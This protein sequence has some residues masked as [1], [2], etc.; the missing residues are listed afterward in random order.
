[1]SGYSDQ[2][3]NRV[4]EVAM[5][6]ISGAGSPPWNRLRHVRKLAIVMAH[7]MLKLE[8]GWANRCVNAA[9]PPVHGSITSVSSS[10]GIHLHADDLST[11]A[12]R[13]PL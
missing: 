3:T 11:Q 7:K 9:K 2:E 6:A 5:K 1:M 8:V 13:E 10:H 4:F 12:L